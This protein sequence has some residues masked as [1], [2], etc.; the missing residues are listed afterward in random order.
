MWLLGIELRSFGKAA[1]ALNR[2]VVSPAQLFSIF[3]IENL[4]FSFL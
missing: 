3:N 2:C 1:S 4:F